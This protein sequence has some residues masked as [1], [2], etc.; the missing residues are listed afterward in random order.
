MIDIKKIDLS[1]IPS[2]FYNAVINKNAKGIINIVKYNPNLSLNVIKFYNTV[3]KLAYAYKNNSKS[4]TCYKVIWQ[5]I[6]KD[7]VILTVPQQ[8]FLYMYCVQSP[9][10]YFGFLVNTINSY[11]V[12]LRAAMKMINNKEYACYYFPLS[13]NATNNVE[14]KIFISKFITNNNVI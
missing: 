1:V 6:D 2:V 14:M 5:N 10:S 11:L 3:L 7:N 13:I 4:N 9:Y 12:Q 8:Y